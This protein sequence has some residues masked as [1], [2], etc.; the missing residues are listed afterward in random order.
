MKG[1]IYVRVSSGEQVAGTSLNYQKQLCEEYCVK[2]NIS[3]VDYFNMLNPKLTEIEKNYV[4]F[5]KLANPDKTKKEIKKEYKD[6]VEPYVNYSKP[7]VVIEVA[8]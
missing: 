4:D 3:Q 1:I 5:E 8:K 6:I 2:N 7:S